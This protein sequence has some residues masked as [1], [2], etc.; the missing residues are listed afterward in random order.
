MKSL[1]EILVGLFSAYSEL[2]SFDPTA[3]LSRL[4]IPEYI[5]GRL[6]RQVTDDR[7]NLIHGSAVIH[8]TAQVSHSI[9]GPSVRICEF[10]TV[11]NCLVSANSVVGHCTEI[12]RTIIGKDCSL[13]RF[14]YVGGS[15]LGDRVRLGG[16][17]SIASRRFDQSP[18]NVHHG[19]EKHP[20]NLLKFGALIGDDTIIG[21]SSHVNP[22]M[23]VGQRCLIGP[24]TDIRRSIPDDYLVVASQKLAVRAR[25]RENSP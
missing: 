4:Q 8:P 13:P 14:N 21:F 25:R 11:R 17:V 16:C 3:R 23:I 10:T 15:I 5:S 9:V 24:Y 12:A 2:V 18:V 22:G 1:E 20:T 7:G 19:A 6:E